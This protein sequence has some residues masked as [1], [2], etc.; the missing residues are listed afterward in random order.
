MNG[1]THES[2]IV[3]VSGKP[4]KPSFGR[5]IPGFFGRTTLS[6]LE[7]RVAENTRRIVSRRYSE[8]PL[9]EVDSAEMTARG[10]R[11]W[12]LL[13]LPTLPLLPV[14]LTFIILYFVKKRRFL[15]IHSKTTSQVVA[16][17]HDV[18]QYRQFMASVLSAAEKAKGGPQ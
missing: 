8:I 6:L 15:V 10:N 14:S 3:W 16:I 5:L 12:V 7:T 9:A 13:G 18:G 17:K 11:N 4:A 1:N 2:A